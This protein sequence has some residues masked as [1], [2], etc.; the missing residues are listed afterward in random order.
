MTMHMLHSNTLYSHAD[1]YR[2]TDRET[3][4]RTGM[5]RH[6]KTPD[7]HRCLHAHLIESVEAGEQTFTSLHIQRYVGR[8][9]QTHKRTVKQIQDHGVK[10]QRQIR[11]GNESIV[12]YTR[13]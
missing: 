6:T 5:I 13:L 9:P 3:G 8:H 4:R 1:A 2:Q 10:S 7:M 12:K 11:R